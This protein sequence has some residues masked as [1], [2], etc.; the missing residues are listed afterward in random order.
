MRAW[1]LPNE[2]IISTF[3]H[4]NESYKGN[5]W[6]YANLT[7]ISNFLLKDIALSDMKNAPIPDTLLNALQLNESVIAEAHQELLNH[8]ENLD[9]MIESLFN[10]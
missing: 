8:K 7:Y 3:E 10:H 5:Y 2:I 4:H 9:G 6:Q 1:G